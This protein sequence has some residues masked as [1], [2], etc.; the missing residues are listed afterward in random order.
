MTRLVSFWRGHENWPVILLTLTFALYLVPLARFNDIGKVGFALLALGGFFYLLFNP[1]RVLDTG[2][3]ERFFFIAVLANF[4]W[5]ATTFYL[6]GQPGSGYS[7]VWSRHFYQLFLIP[8]YYLFRRVEI[9]DRI[10]VMLIALGVL[11]SLGDML[12]GMA[13]GIDYRN[14]GSNPNGFGP[15]Q[16]CLSGMLLLFF[17]NNPNDPQRWIALLVFVAGIV[18]VVLSQSRNTWVTLVVLSVVF[19]LYQF[20]RRSGWFRLGML[21]V[22]AIVILGSY[23][24]PVVKSRV[25][26]GIESVARYHAS[27]NYR[28]K[29]RLG[30]YGT[31][32][33]LWKTGWKIFLEH[34]VIGAGVGNFSILAK[35]NSKRYKVNN[36]VH[37][38]KYVHNQYIAA[39][40]TRG[41]P[42]LI[43]LLLLLGSP[44]YI[45]L[46]HRSQDPGEEVARLSIILICLVYAIGCIAEDHLEVR[47]SPR[48][49]IV[50]LPLLLARINRRRQPTGGNGG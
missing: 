23:Q 13:E 31:R 44:I 24:L 29:S 32:M 18:T 37:S 8:L 45:A 26:L 9:P 38:Y 1:K 2:P 35:K 28:D 42:G 36:V 4:T 41:F 27:E 47:A 3:R 22:V 12:V 5:I 30:T 15:I 21:T 49:I 33:E 11:L 46:K 39:L 14:E 48:F 20:R 34:P 43:L 10:M 19:A 7:I 50:M 40:A 6:N 25:D 16:L 17:I